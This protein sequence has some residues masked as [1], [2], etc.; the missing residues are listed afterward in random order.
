MEKIK[1]MNPIV[2]MDGDEMTRILWREIKDTLIHPFVE[3]KTEYY[4]LG[5]PNRNKTNDQVTVEA[6]NAIKKWRVG[7]KCATI[8]PNAQR[9]EEYRLRQ[10][11]KSPNGTIRSILDGTVFRAPILVDRIAPV[12]S[13]WKKPITIA[14]HAY[15]DVYR[16][17]EY[18]VPGAG[19]AELVFTD[20]SGK[21]TFRQEVFS[22]NG[23]GVVQGM[24]NT[25]KY[26]R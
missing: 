7:V 11:W 25:D 2:E 8:T 22:F 1:I 6:A 16:N 26:I 14:R 19:K 24:H 13:T 15:G 3:L 18:R 4:D 20:T 17:V 12:V 21:E 10:M 23:P 5:L 9:M